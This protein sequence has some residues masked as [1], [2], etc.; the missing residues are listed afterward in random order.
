MLI[1][2]DFFLFLFLPFIRLSLTK[3]I[4]TLASFKI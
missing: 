1:D 3:E 2:L 4:L